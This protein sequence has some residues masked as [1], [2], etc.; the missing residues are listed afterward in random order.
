MVRFK[1]CFGGKANKTHQTV[2]YEIMKFFIK[3]FSW[4][5]EK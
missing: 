3:N 5:N 4:N 2:P 1:V